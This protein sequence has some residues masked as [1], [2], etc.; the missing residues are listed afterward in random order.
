[1]PR[2]LRLVLTGSGA[3]SCLIATVITG[4]QLLAVGLSM[5]RLTFMGAPLHDSTAAFGG[6]QRMDNAV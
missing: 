5:A 1:M 2:P 6:V 4:T 3:A